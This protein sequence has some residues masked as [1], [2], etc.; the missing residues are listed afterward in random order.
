M[1]A[2]ASRVRRTEFPSVKIGKRVPVIFIN[3]MALNRDAP[4]AIADCPAK[5][6][7]S[8]P[9]DMG[10]SHGSQLRPQVTSIRY[11]NWEKSVRF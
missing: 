11:Y 1:E 7:Q 2:Q 4:G 6:A 3:I 10:G 8:R 9:V 5:S